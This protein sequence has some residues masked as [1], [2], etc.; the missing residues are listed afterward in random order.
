MVELDNN[1]SWLL[2][3]LL[4]PSSEIEGLSIED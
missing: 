2:A 1:G 4:D 3:F